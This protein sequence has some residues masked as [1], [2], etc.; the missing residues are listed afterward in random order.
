LHITRQQATTE[1]LHM[2]QT[3]MVLETLHT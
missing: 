3:V 1:L 2:P